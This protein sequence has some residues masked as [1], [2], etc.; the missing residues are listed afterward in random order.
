MSSTYSRHR[1]Q[2]EAKQK[3]CTWLHGLSVVS[4]TKVRLRSTGDICGRGRAGA[5][6]HWC[7]YVERPRRQTEGRTDTAHRETGSD[8]GG[9]SLKTGAQSSTE[10]YWLMVKA[11][12]NVIAE[13]VVWFTNY[14]ITSAD[15]VDYLPKPTALKNVY[16]SKRFK[17]GF[18]SR[19]NFLEKY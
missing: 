6:W 7:P 12:G 14:L 15:T 18:I 13:V 3:Y 1:H 2:T 17:R 10:P 4:R 19:V 9:C 11:G 16:S 8:V 5:G